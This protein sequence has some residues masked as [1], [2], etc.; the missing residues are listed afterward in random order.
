LERV[1]GYINEK[2]ELIIPPYFCYAGHFINGQ[3]SV[4]WQING[5]LVGG[6]IDTQGNII[7]IDD[8]SPEAVTLDAE[9]EET[10][11]ELTPVERIESSGK[12]S[13][14]DNNISEEGLILVRNHDGL[15]GFTDSFGNEVIPCCYPFATA[16]HNGLAAVS[17]KFVSDEDLQWAN[18]YFNPNPISF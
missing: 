15:Y 3:A 12:Y 11:R 10:P 18:S 9:G 6:T 5:K 8:E 4:Q 14:V 16:F 1:Y 7:S 17:D 13:F 2:Q